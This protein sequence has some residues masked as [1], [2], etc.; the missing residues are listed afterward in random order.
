M[1]FSFFNLYIY[2]KR[3]N[4]RQSALS[5]HDISVSLPSHYLLRIVPDITP[6]KIWQ[7]EHLLDDANS[8]ERKLGKQRAESGSYLF[9][10]LLASHSLLAFGSDW[11]VR[12]KLLDLYFLFLLL[13]KVV[14]FVFF[15]RC[16]R[17]Q[18]LILWTP[19]GQRWRGFPQRGKHHGFHLNASHSTMHLMRK[20]H[21]FV[22]TFIQILS[23]FDVSCELTV[24]N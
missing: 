21:Q 11:P 17:L 18:T 4:K 16:F 5:I 14:I 7:P 12:T 23:V 19:L 8:A 3:G 22:L 2:L 24:M 10:S 13:F 9:Q 15:W 6:C 20:A 1:I